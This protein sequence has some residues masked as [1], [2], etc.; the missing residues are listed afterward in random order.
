MHF[1][2]VFFCFFPTSI[3][4]NSYGGGGLQ[5]GNVVHRASSVKPDLYQDKRGRTVR[6]SLTANSAKPHCA[7]TPGCNKGSKLTPEEKEIFNKNGQRNS[8]EI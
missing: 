6:C 3:S 5:S 4:Y 2:T 8:R 1:E 7:L